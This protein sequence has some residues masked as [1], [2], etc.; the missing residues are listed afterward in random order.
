[1]MKKSFGRGHTLVRNKFRRCFP[2]NGVRHMFLAVNDDGPSKTGLK[3][4]FIVSSI[5]LLNR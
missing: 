5:K 4:N 1:M 3:H 2:R